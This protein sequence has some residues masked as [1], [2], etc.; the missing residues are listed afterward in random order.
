M[1]GVEV[2]EEGRVGGGWERCEGRPATEEERDQGRSREAEGRRWGTVRGCGGAQVC[3]KELSWW[4]VK[5]LDEMFSIV[6]VAPSLETVA[7]LIFRMDL[8]SL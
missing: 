3:P 6:T 4:K 2:E 7:D 8:K 5:G 1:G